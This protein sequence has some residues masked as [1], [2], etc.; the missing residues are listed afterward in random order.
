M[1]KATNKTNKKSIVKA[2]NNNRS[3]GSGRKQHFWHITNFKELFELTD[4]I[5]KKRPGPLTYTKSVVTVSGKSNPAE[6]IHYERMRDL[7]SRPNRHL[8]RS[9]FE[10]LK[11]WTGGKH[12]GQRGYLIT[13]NCKPACYRYLSAQ[14]T[15]EVKELREAMTELEQI[16]LLEKV[17]I[18]GQFDNSDSS[19]TKLDKNGKKRKP[20]KKDK[21]KYKV[22]SENK[23]K[24]NKK[25]GIESEGETQ[26][27][28][29]ITYD[30]QNAVQKGNEAEDSTIPTNSTK[31]D[32]P[33]K[34]Q[35]SNAKPS[36]TPDKSHIGNIINMQSYRYDQASMEFALEVMLK[37]GLLNDYE[38]QRLR[39]G[40]LQ[41]TDEQ[42]AERGNWAKA[43][44]EASGEF[45]P[46]TI[47][48][49]K[50]EIFKRVPAALKN[51]KEPQAYLRTSWNNL[52]K[53]IRR[54][55]QPAH[56]SP[57]LS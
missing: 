1:A 2:G 20:L 40:C 22:E 28:N 44:H 26:N 14:L 35:G 54:K 43:W 37:L 18:D 4:D 33:G 34:A 15:I 7:K 10:D 19:R 31:A 57:A 36:R 39:D 3:T 9:V 25:I 48:K 42:A 52:V 49:L 23:K 45:G 47:A 51:G 16:G 6:V 12:Y 17:T 30:S 8:L 38:L 11:N 41:L 46:E 55:K 24:I 56:A 32:A 50:Q 13:T 29:N 53:D 27:H 21:S 5:R